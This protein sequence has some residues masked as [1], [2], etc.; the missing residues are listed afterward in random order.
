M[1]TSPEPRNR[2]LDKLIVPTLKTLVVGVAILGLLLF[3]PAG[4][5]NYWQAWVLI[6]IFVLGSNAIGIYLSVHDPELLERRKQAGPTA[7]TR[8][9][10]KIIISVL[11]VALIGMLIVSALDHRFGWS[12]VPASVSL[13]A[14]LLAAVG[15]YITFLVVRENTFSASNISVF[16]DQKVISTG[17]YAFVRHP[18]Y[19]GTLLLTLASP[20]ALGSWWGLLPVLLVV[21]MLVWRIFD[22]EKLLKAELPGY[23]DYMR[24]VRYR[25]VPYGW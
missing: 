1:S 24:R 7:E 17:P 8:P 4:T 6:A 22:E 2:I 20:L 16:K 3:L 12:E 25:L 5:L 14:D 15:L 19:S 13:A 23:S 18:M 11:I 21:P 9:A 10:Q